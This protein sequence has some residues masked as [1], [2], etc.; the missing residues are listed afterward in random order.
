MT[1]TR[2]VSA[3]RHACLHRRVSESGY[4]CVEQ[5]HTSCKCVGGA[6]QE[7]QGRW[8]LGS[9]PPRRH[10]LAPPVR[11]YLPDIPRMPP[12]HKFIEKPTASEVKYCATL[13]QAELSSRTPEEHM[14][15]EQDRLHWEHDTAVTTVCLILFSCTFHLRATF[16]SRYD[17]TSVTRSH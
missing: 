1:F 8:A 12:P 6:G 11:S 10:S 14:G 15:G 16:I 2:V 3:L 9:L 5:V 7:T 13:Q 4:E 17:G